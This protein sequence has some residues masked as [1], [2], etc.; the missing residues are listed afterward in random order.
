M[1]SKRSM[2][3]FISK[4]VHIKVYVST[5]LDNTSF[6]VP[7]GTC[8]KAG[9]PVNTE[10]W[11]PDYLQYDLLVHHIICLSYDHDVQKWESSNCQVCCRRNVYVLYLHC[12]VYHQY[13]IGS[14]QLFLFRYLA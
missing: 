3:N 4:I 1:W 7:D 5:C 14:L 13:I 8:P 9:C 2:S 11:G 10:E 6:G 12:V